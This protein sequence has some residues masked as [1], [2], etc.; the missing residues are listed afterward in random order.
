MTYLSTSGG[1]ATLHLAD[2]VSGNLLETHVL[3][4]G[5]SLYSLDVLNDELFVSRRDVGGGEV[6]VYSITPDRAVPSLSPIG[7]ALLC[8]LLGFAGWRKFRS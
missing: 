4:S 6:W 8:S 1:G 3:F 5:S 2:P 7:M